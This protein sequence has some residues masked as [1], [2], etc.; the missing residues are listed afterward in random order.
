VECIIFNRPE[1]TS[2]KTFGAAGLEGRYMSSHTLMNPLDYYRNGF[3]P[4]TFTKFGAC[5]PV[6]SHAKFTLPLLIPQH[7]SLEEKLFI[8]EWML[9]QL[10]KD[11]IE[12]NEYCKQKRLDR[13]IH[14]FSGGLIL[15]EIPEQTRLMAVCGFLNISIDLNFCAGGKNC[16]SYND[17]EVPKMASEGCVGPCIDFPLGFR[18]PRNYYDLLKKWNDPHP[19]NLTQRY[20]RR[21][22]GGM[23]CRSC[24]HYEC[25]RVRDYPGNLLPVGRWLEFIHLFQNWEARLALSKF[26][27]INYNQ[28]EVGWNRLCGTGEYCDHCVRNMTCSQCNA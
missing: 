28:D 8:Y 23:P 6:P 20:R 24:G 17:A 5:M 2:C 11:E 4:Q 14:Y 10:R 13:N 19:F 9:Y 7:F 18:I 26:G 3:K 25:K 27:G 22:E 16:Y 21:E 12:W 15:H 1:L